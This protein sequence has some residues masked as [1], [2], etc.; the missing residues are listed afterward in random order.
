MSTLECFSEAVNVDLCVVSVRGSADMEN[1]D[2]MHEHFSKVAA[3]SSRWVIIDMQHLSFL[4]S[5]AIG[6]IVSLNKAKKAKGGHVCLSA[7]NE[8][9]GSIINKVRLD[10]TVKVFPNLDAAMEAHSAKFEPH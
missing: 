9:I 4:T 10:L 1:H 8:Y 5:L 6:E 7:P 3:D 2:A